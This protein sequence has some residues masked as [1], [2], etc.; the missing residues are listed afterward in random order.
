MIEPLRNRSIASCTSE[1]R[2]RG[3]NVYPDAAMVPTEVFPCFVVEKLLSAAISPDISDDEGEGEDGASTPVVLNRFQSR[4]L[5]ESGKQSGTVLISSTMNSL[6]AREMF[7]SK[8]VF[9]AF[10]PERRMLD[11]PF[12]CD[13][14]RAHLFRIGR[15]TVESLSSAKGTIIVSMNN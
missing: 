2:L 6:V 14:F 10:K 15:T 8:V 5:H 13:T 11:C 4:Y 9:N 1:S 12:P 7:L 3:L